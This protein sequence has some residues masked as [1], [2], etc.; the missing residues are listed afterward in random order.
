MNRS[1]RLAVVHSAAVVAI[2]AWGALAFGAVYEWAYRPLA[3]ACV[4]S[5]ALMIAGA[6]RRVRL[7]IAGAVAAVLAAVLLQQVP[8][9]RAMLGRLSPAAPQLLAQYDVA[10]ALG[11]PSHALSIDPARTW[12]AVLLFVSFGLFWIGLAAALTDSTLRRIAGGVVGT[13]FV[14]AVAG[15]VAGAIDGSRV[16]GFWQPESHAQSF[17]PFVNRNHFAGWMLMAVPLGGGYLIDLIAGAR[18]RERSW[19]QRLVWL[20]TPAAGRVVPIGFALVVMTLSVFFSLSRSG[21]TCLLCALLV[22]ATIA[23]AR[24]ACGWHRVVLPALVTGVIVACAV[25]AGTDVLA[26]RFE[27]RGSSWPERRTAW[28]DA[29]ALASRFR[30]TGTGMNTFRTAEIVAQSRDNDRLFAE[31]HNDYL[32]VASE[33][34]VLVGAPALLLIAVI[35]REVRRN[36]A[37]DSHGRWPW[38]RTGALVGLAGVAIQEFVDFS[39]QMPGNAALFCVLAAVV[40]HTPQ[41]S[42]VPQRRP[43]A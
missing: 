42:R 31:A 10:F 3:L 32:Q 4:A 21:I 13:G 11:S 26:A 15:I 41:S 25:W 36:R 27:E 17:G 40:V 5:G 12:T 16:L 37:R 7:P 2:V 38:I 9:P 20:S 14:I 39:L 34:G 8:L 28:H 30:W 6:P 19:R 18:L 22:F 29:A 24:L 33:G 43:D 23:A 1:R 35:V